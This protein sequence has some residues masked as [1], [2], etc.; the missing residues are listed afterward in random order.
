MDWRHILSCRDRCYVT[1]ESFM[2][3]NR[4]CP[5]QRARIFL[6][7]HTLRSAEQLMVRLVWFVFLVLQ[8]SDAFML[9]TGF[10][11]AGVCSHQEVY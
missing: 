8:F 2:H 11:P 6:D 7:M 1:Q 9:G 5:G 10:D 4:Q 3:G